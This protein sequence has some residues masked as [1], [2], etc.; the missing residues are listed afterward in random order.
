MR[1]LPVLL[2]ATLALAPIAYA[3]K[4][5][6]TAQPEGQRLLL[7]LTAKGVQI[8]ACKQVDANPQWVFQAPEATLFNEK[9]EKVGA[10]VAGPVWKYRDGS[11]VKGETVATSPAP[12]PDSIPWLLIHA[13]NSQGSGLMSRVDS[14]RRT[15]THGGIAPATGCDA[16]HLNTTVR[17]PYTATYNFYSTQP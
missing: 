16:Q 10:H 17:V 12:V 2:A 1:S 15:G 9:G 7:S 13:V 14:I 5:S 6:P 4:E 8:Y 3:Q 11:Q